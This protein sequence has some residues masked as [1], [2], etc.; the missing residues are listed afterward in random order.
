MSSVYLHAMAP[1]QAVKFRADCLQQ[2]VQQGNMAPT[3]TNEHQNSLQNIIHS[4]RHSKVH[5]D[6]H[7]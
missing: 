3:K 5:E 4:S 2:F 7:E 6:T 1:E